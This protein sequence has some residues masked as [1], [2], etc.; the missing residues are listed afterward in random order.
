MDLT[1]NL[2]ENCQAIPDGAHE[3][4]TQDSPLFLHEFQQKGKC[5]SPI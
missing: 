2:E 4:K 3:M 5:K 1:V